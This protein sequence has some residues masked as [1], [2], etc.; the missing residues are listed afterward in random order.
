MKTRLWFRPLSRRPL[1]PTPPRVRARARLAVEALEDR[2]VP[3]TIVV[4]NP[5]DTPAL[6]TTD[7]RQA[8]A[9][10]NAAG[11]GQSITF[12]PTVFATPQTILLSGTQLELSD[13]T[14]PETIT[15]PAAG[16]TVSGGGNSRVFQV[17]ALVTASLSGLTITGGKAATNGGGLSNLGTLT[18]A[19][20]TVSGNAT[21]N[22]AFGGGVYN[23]GTLALTNCTV[24]GNSA[25]GDCG[26][27]CSGTF[28]N[29]QTT[30]TLTNCTLS[31]N[32]ATYYYTGLLATGT[33]VMTNT[34]VA[35]NQ[36]YRDLRPVG[37]G[38]QQPDRH[39]LRGR[40]HQRGQRQPRRGRQPAAGPAGQ[41]RRPEP[42]RGPAAGQPGAQ[43]RHHRP[44]H[45]RHRPA[46][47]RPG[48]RPDIGAFESQGFTLTAAPGSTPQTAQIGTPF[49]HPLAVSVAAVNPVE[50]VNGGVLAFASQPAAG[51]ATALLSAPSAVIS[52]GQAAVTA[53]PNNVDG[54]Y[55]VVVSTTGFS[56]PIQLTNSG[57]VFASLV[58]NTTS[59]ALTP[60][61]GLL[62][63][64]EAV[65]FDNTAP[66]GN[67]PITFSN[68]VFNTAQTIH[69]T[70]SQLELSNP[71]GTAA[72]VGP[73]A[74]VTIDGGGLSR[75]FQVDNL[76]TASF[77]GLTIT[78][79]KAATNGGGLS[80]SGTLTL[81][82]CTVSGN[83][84]TNS[85][86]GGGLFN[87][88]TLT[89]TNCTV[90]G[91]SAY[92]G[93]GVASE[94]VANSRPAL[95][96][97]N[98]TVSANSATY[99]SGL[100][101]TGTTTLTNTIVAGNPLPGTVYLPGSEI[102]ASS[103]SG[104]NNLIGI[105]SVIGLTNGVNGNL[106]GVAHPGLAPLGGYGGPTQTVALL[107][108][109]P[110]LNAGATGPGI[111]STD[112]R[113]LGR[114]GA[115]DIGAFESQGF[116]FAVVPGSTPQAAQIGTPFAHPL[117]VSVAAVNPAEPVN[118]GVLA[119]VG[120]PAAGGA[121]ALLS[122]PSAVIS[123]GQAAVTAAPNNVDG[124][125]NVV[126]S[127]PGF[128][129]AF[130]LTN[131]GPVFASLVVNTTSDAL[132]PGAGLLSLREAVGFD[133]TA[134]AGNT[135]ITFSSSVF[136]TAQDDPPDRQ[137]ARAEQHHRDGGD[138][139]T[140][141][142]GDH[143]RRW[144]ERGLPG[145][146][147]GHGV[148]LGLDP[149]RRQDRRQRRRPVQQRYD[150]ANRLHGQRQHR[151]PVR[152]RPGPGETRGH[153]DADRLHR[154]WQL[155]LSRRRPVQRRHGHADQLYRQRQ[156]LYFS[157]RFRQRRRPLQQGHTD[158]VRL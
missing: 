61:V 151:R 152:R 30:L 128:S 129:A 75:V 43:R 35:G 26:G 66:A 42:D 123:G 53:V 60:G 120:Q 36:G 19:N 136:N 141:G 31:A 91:N 1:T 112:Q 57:P 82:G 56:V 113:G 153:L 92:D 154:R 8:I 46:R 71:T 124:S 22:S 143:R 81:T 125:Y 98:C 158:D 130:Q 149:H 37:V 84:V 27:V 32:S 20:C 33:T 109:S 134:P 59:D 51:G 39:G 79:G 15:G 116:R 77:S 28:A 119:F 23:G 140:A 100:L 67:T 111:P 144:P 135:P 29:T 9:Q 74:G 12:D 49:A 97:T 2:W 55:A 117:A 64:R 147:A 99:Y 5:T 95:I 80:S 62:S 94:S 132:A 146:R 139:R 150:H 89:L 115:P 76:V 11:G 96:L 102:Y 63:L 148:L 110:A 133:N 40:A 13:T 38:H 41:L 70:G 21:T 93:G 88:G 54:S 4:T 65:A 78:G 103:A 108:G 126:A 50:P 142:G 87:S 16:V 24:S 104:A 85:A 114:V 34:I 6:G 157:F 131:S 121:T 44:R 48:R 127:T 72:I 73:S 14:G 122:A 156:R 155:R 45:P 83:A 17:D 86:F 105:G 145:G 90:S 69:L 101:A 47:P 3:S 18:M 106:L 58:V 137:P 118:G 52:S 25:S 7:L 138:R 107:P 10:A 68:S